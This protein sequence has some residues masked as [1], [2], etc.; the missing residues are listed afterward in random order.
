MH[1]AHGI[2]TAV[3]LYVAVGAVFAMVFVT[4]GVGQVDSAAR[5]SPILFR[6]LIFPGTTALWPLLAVHWV[7][8]RRR[9][10]DH[11]T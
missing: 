4:V 3:L 11:A 6:V 5:G 10:T 8:A 9:G 1:L 2:I 7:R